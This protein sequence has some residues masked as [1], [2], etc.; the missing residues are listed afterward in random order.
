MSL[1]YMHPLLVALLSLELVFG[2]A[3][4]VLPSVL[5]GVSLVFAPIYK[6]LWRIDNKSAN[7]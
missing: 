5:L 7:P 2:F 1:G 6:N 3:L 4:K